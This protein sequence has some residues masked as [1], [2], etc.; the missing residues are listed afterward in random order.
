MGANKWPRCPRSFYQVQCSSQC[1]SKTCYVL[2]DVWAKFTVL[3][4]FIAQA[5]A[6]GEC[7][8]FSGA[9][10]ELLKA[11]PQQYQ[12][13]L[14]PSILSGSHGYELFTTLFS[15][16]RHIMRNSHSFPIQRQSTAY[17]LL[18]QSSSPEGPTV[19]RD[20]YSASSRQ[21]HQR[22]YCKCN[23]NLYI[24]FRET[25]RPSDENSQSILLLQRGSESQALGQF[26]GTITARMIKQKPKDWRNLSEAVA[27][28]NRSHRMFCQIGFDEP[29]DAEWRPHKNSQENPPEIP[30]VQIPW[31]MKMDVHLCMYACMYLWHLYRAFKNLIEALLTNVVFL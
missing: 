18:L 8:G 12:K 7:K 5:A 30:E 25:P 6:P 22:H 19:I 26:S 16:P 28:K 20:L 9:S 10:S 23:C 13:P 27:I 4:C 3:K 14:D 21:F 17:A 31:P 29:R 1:W 15:W 11:A 24:S 2:I